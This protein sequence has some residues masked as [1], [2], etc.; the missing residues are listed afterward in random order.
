L[1]PLLL[2]VTALEN[3]HSGGT[4]AGLI[5]IS[6]ILIPQMYIWTRSQAKTDMYRNRKGGTGGSNH[7][8]QG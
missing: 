1:L 4:W 8:F 7:F 2:P 5:P 3:H 6:M